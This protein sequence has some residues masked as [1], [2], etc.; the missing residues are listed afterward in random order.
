MH[1]STNY[2]IMDRSH[3]YGVSKKRSKNQFSIIF[4]NQMNIPTAEQCRYIGII[5]SVK[6]SDL[7]INRQMRKIYAKVIFCPGKFQ[8]VLLM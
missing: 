5:V 2:Y 7:H 4:L 6:N 8:N 3:L 1:L